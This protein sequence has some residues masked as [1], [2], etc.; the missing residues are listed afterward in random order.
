MA[1]AEVF[2]QLAAAATGL[3]PLV[4]KSIVLLPFVSPSIRD[5]LWPIASI[6]SAVLAYG[7]YRGLSYYMRGV[8]QTSRRGSLPY[9]AI[10]IPLVLMVICLFIMIAIRGKIF[11][12]TP[13]GT[14]V[15]M[16]IS[17]VSFFFSLCASLGASLGLR[18]HA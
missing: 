8:P 9:F 12:L 4:E 6:S 10:G 7:L 14:D 2:V 1:K 3:L 18:R 11:L 15:L 5:E 16:Q 17:Y 13:D